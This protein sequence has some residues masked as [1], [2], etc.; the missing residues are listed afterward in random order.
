MVTRSIN[1]LL[2]PLIRDLLPANFNAEGRL[3]IPASIR[4]E[5]ALYAMNKEYQLDIGEKAKVTIFDFRCSDFSSDKSISNK[6]LEKDTHIKHISLG[7]QAELNHIVIQLGPKERAHKKNT[8]YQIHQEEGSLYRNTT[9]VLGGQAN[10]I[11]TEV[12]LNQPYACCESKALMLG[13]KNEQISLHLTV[14]HKK[15]YVQSQILSRSLMNNNAKGGFFGKLIIDK[16]ANKTRT[17]LENKNLL[18]A[19]NAEVNTT[20]QLEIYHDDVQ[21][22]HGATVG[23]LEEDA[24]FYLRSRGISE[25]IAKQMLIDAFIYPVLGTLQERSDQADSSNPSNKLLNVL[26]GLIHEYN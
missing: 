13:S 12:F 26:T 7:K 25:K 18:L 6:N 22:T 1:A 4:I 16:G 21:C 9:F 3:T 20:P 23:H 11:Q 17:Q 10:H 2:E 24:L 14:H 15:P 19:K 8:H 5:N